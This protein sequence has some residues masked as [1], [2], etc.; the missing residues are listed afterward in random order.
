L[1]WRKTIYNAVER[2]WGYQVLI[3]ATQPAARGSFQDY[4]YV[5]WVPANGL[6]TN[7]NMRVGCKASHAIRDK[8][9]QQ[10]ALKKRTN[11]S[12]PRLM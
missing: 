9:R 4:G 2:Q 7:A 8:W 11:F 1:G 5:R 10:A 12:P 6:A 3:P